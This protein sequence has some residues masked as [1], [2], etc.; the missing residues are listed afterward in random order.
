MSQP[1]AQPSTNTQAQAK[2]QIASTQ[3]PEITR[4]KESGNEAFKNKKF[5][6]AGTAYFNVTIIGS[7]IRI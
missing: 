5:E 3:F 7:N 1:A 4:L 6:E 2:P